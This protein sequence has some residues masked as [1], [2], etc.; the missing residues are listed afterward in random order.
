MLLL[1]KLNIRTVM[2]QFPIPVS[3]IDSLFWLAPSNIVQGAAKRDLDGGFSTLGDGAPAGGVD[4]DVG[5]EARRRDRGVQGQ[6]CL[7]R[8]PSKAG[9]L[10]TNN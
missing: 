6:Q 8:I 4:G 10:Q 7:E 2:L 9:N 1:L 3:Y 5:L